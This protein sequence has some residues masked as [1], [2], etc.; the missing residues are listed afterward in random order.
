MFPITAA[1]RC[2]IACIDRLIVH[3]IPSWLVLAPWFPAFAQDA[4]QAPTQPIELPAISV[5][6]SPP[7]PPARPTNQASGNSVVV[8]PTTVPTLSE[9][10]AS[11][12]TVITAAD[13]QAQQIRTVPDALAAVPGLNIVQ[14]GGP[15]SQTSVFIRGT[16]SNHVKVLIDSID[17]SDPSNPNQSYDFGQLLTGDIARIEV[18]RGPQSGLYG[19]DAIGG[20]ISITTKTGDGP[21]KMTVTGDGGSFSTFNRRVGLSGSQNNF[22]YVFNIQHFSSLDNPVTPLNQ[23]APGEQRINDTYNNYTYST[24]LG[25]NLT[26]NLAVNLVGRYTDSMLGFTGEDYVN[27]FPPAPEALQ[28]TQVDHQF[29]GRGEAVWSLFDDRFK[30]FFGVNYTNA[31]SWNLDPNPDSFN[32]PPAIAPP[33]TNLGQRTQYD[34]RGEARVVARQ[35]LV[36]GLE[37]KTESLS[38]NSTGSFNSFGVYTPTTTTAQTGDKA[39]WVEL[40]SAFADQFFVVSNIR[41]DDNESYGDHTTWRIAPAFIV[42]GTDTKLKAT[43][44]TGFKAPT[45]TE[46]YVSN[47]SFMVVGNPNLSPETSK[48]YD[49]G[50]EQPLLHD[51]LRVG[52]TYFHNDITNLIEG[53]TNPTTFVSTY[54]NVGQATTRGVETFAAFSL[55]SRLN[56]R[57]DHTYTEARDDL[58]GMELLRRPMNKASL[59]AFWNVTDRLV[60]TGQAVYVGSWLDY[61]RPGTAELMAPGY[62]LVNLS[63]N[64][65]VTDR[66]SVFGR[67][68]NL[69]NQQYEDPL[70]F[71]RPGFGVYGGFRVQVGGVP[72]SLASSDAAATT[73]APSSAPSIKGGGVR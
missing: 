15:G 67:I 66:I 64:Y 61:N 53:T 70:G 59:T 55:N 16:N 46:L 73:A 19:S 57:A 52:A 33:T 11:S 12:T 2:S 44:G 41:L 40:Q 6:V 24:K 7:S 45:L 35:I 62:T 21:L 72:T 26:D 13:I 69:L 51:R 63:A 42:P 49:V 18:L 32:A 34:W 3:V 1:M 43:Y 50:F 10:S 68:N 9:Q 28:S 58:T 20:V 36:F 48:G 30:N 37:D 65:A 4:Q 71:L 5:T 38:T 29:Y 27:F 22:N 39:A 47:P 14:T 60:V 8:S 54:V 56:L 23:L 31:W 25:V 17:V